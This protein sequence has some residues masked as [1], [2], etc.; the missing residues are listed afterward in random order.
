MLHG[1]AALGVE[2]QDLESLAVQLTPAAE[3]TKLLPGT[4]RKVPTL[5]CGE[6]D[7]WQ[8]TSDSRN[9][10]FVLRQT[11]NRCDL[12]LTFA[13][14]LP[15]YKALLSAPPGQYH[16]GDRIVVLREPD[17]SRTQK[18]KR[19]VGVPPASK[20]IVSGSAQ[21]QF[22][23]EMPLDVICDFILGPDM[24]VDSGWFAQYFGVAYG[25]WT[26]AK[27]KQ[28]MQMC[29]AVVQKIGALSADKFGSILC[30]GS[31]DDPGAQS[32]VKGY[33][34][35][36]AM[37]GVH[38]GKFPTMHPV[39]DMPLLCQTN[40]GALAADLA[41]DG[42]IW[43]NNRS[44]TAIVNLIRTALSQSTK[45]GEF[46]LQSAT[47]A[48]AQCLEEGKHPLTG[49]TYAGPFRLDMLSPRWLGTCKR[50]Q[51]VLE[52]RR[53]PVLPYTDWLGASEAAFDYFV[54]DKD[55]RFV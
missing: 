3:M 30:P 33:L 20:P 1:Y 43:N 52:L 32:L 11:G 18:P 51:V 36:L 41:K 29:Q 54:V 39:K 45:K 23:I 47:N 21:L 19:T 12:H 15:L 5:C 17:S 22:N 53:M 55:R 37:C 24:K 27:T 35:L 6:D 16:V 34:S 7:W 28:E 9:L 26:V 2:I 40:L 48:I 49:V 46:D 8:F 38:L 44:Q 31:T 13:D 4:V 10:E 42:I 14:I 50:F 25:F